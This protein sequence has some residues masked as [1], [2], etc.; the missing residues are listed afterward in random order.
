M[1]SCV[2]TVEERRCWV[3]PGIIITQCNIRSSS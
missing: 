1:G 2:E 3:E